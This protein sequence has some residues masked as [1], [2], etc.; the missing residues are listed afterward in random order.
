[1][2]VGE[3]EKGAATAFEKSE[4]RISWPKAEQSL[5]QTLGRNESS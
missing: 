1:M 4:S 3:V 5:S 2:V